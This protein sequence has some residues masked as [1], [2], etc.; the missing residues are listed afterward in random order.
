MI[1][2]PFNNIKDVGVLRRS[3]EGLETVEV[4]NGIAAR[5]SVCV[6][7]F[8]CL[9]VFWTVPDGRVRGVT[10]GRRKGGADG[11]NHGWKRCDGS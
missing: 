5:L 4:Q 10:S 1:T 8:A 2:H 7:A 6:E 3:E 11:G 9:W